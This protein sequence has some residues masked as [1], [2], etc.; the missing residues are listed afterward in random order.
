LQK[1]FN[2][3]QTDDI[4]EVVLRYHLKDF[5]AKFPKPFYFLAIN[6]TNPSPSFMARFRSEPT[7]KRVSEVKPKTF[8][9]TDKATDKRGVVF[10]ANQ[11]RPIAANQAKVETGWRTSGRG[12]TFGTCLVEK[13]KSGWV[14]IYYAIRGVS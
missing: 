6:H 8:E 11:V 3:Q 7:I 10:Y 9:V 1:T 12:G 14:V 13:Q 4:R 2:P 5:Q